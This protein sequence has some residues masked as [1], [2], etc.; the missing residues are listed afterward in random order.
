MDDLSLP[1]QS[2]TVEPQP[3]IAIPKEIINQDAILTHKPSASINYAFA[4]DGGKD[5]ILVVFLNG[6]MTDKVTWIPVIAGIIRRRIGT[7]AGFP[8]MLAYD[9]YGQGMSDDGDPADH[10]K[11]KGHGHDCWD[12]AED[13]HALVEQVAK[14]QMGM[15]QENL[16]IVLVANSIGCAIARLYA[17]AHPVAAFLF[18]DSIMANSNFDFWPDPDAPD[19]NKDELPEDVSIDVLREQRAKFAVIF[20]PSTINKEGLSRRNLAQLLPH[21]NSP[22]LGKEGNRPWLTVM[23]HDFEAF[24][25][26]S[27]RTMG[28]PVSLSMKYSNPIWHKYNTGLAQLTVKTKSK[29]PFQAKDCGHFIQRDGPAIVVDETL[30]LVDKIRTS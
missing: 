11:D 26:E 16:K 3:A 21:S 5:P 12:A 17:Q 27:L 8:S 2:N 22:M 9:R 29:G 7:D 23:G 4:R 14:E 25:E 10:G 13:L 19:F 24:A 15:K 30:E 1:I 18:L 20:H 28:T 6:L